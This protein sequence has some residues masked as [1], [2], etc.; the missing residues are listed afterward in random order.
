MFE[1]KERKKEKKFKGTRNVF[2]FLWN[3]VNVTMKEKKMEK[4]VHLCKKKLSGQSIKV[5]KKEEEKKRRS[6]STS[7]VFFLA[8]L[9]VYA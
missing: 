3:R 2:C 1:R 4:V 5:V 6:Y 9:R 8:S 7:C